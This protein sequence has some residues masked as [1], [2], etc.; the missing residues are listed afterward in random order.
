MFAVKFETFSQIYS[1]WELNSHENY[2]LQNYLFIKT[3]F[4]INVPYIRKIIENY[5]KFSKE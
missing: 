3:L 2:I 4:Y 1:P 5:K